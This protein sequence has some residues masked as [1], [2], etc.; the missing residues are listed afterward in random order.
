MVPDLEAG[1]CP[2]ESIGSPGASLPCS[3]RCFLIF[4]NADFNLNLRLI[5]VQFHVDNL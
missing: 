3:V 5:P 4:R 1:V 2:T